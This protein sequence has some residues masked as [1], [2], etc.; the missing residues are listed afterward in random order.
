MKTKLATSRLDS[1]HER[2]FS[3]VEAMIASAITLIMFLS[4]YTGITA[5]VTTIQ[6]AR[7]N[8]RATQI[9]INRMEGIRLFTW[10]QLTDT[11]LL[12]NNFTEN[13]YP[14]GATGKQGITYT[15]VVTV[16]SV[17]LS[18]PASSYSNNLYQVVI[19]LNWKSGNVQR[20]RQMS[21]FCAKYGMQNYIWSNP[22]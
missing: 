5:G 6:I 18:S 7:E 19:R 20:T 4:F 13:Y 22:N 15:G 10:T 1:R 3:L 16:A 21:T 17:A 2:G 8:L 11:T 9:M 12:P 14:G